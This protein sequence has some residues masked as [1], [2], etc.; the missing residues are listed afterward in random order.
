MAAKALDFSA[1]GYLRAAAVAP[2]VRIADPLANAQQILGHLER[3]E[4]SGAA[5]ALFPELS[6]TGYT[7]EDLFCNA[8]LLQEAWRAL[9]LI[10]ERASPVVA[11]VGLPWASPDSRLFNCAAVVSGGR[12]A[13]LVP[14]SCIPNHGEFYERRW[15][16]S[17]AGLNLPVESNL[18]DFRVCPNQLF[19]IGQHRIAVELCE[20]LWAPQPPGAAHSLAGAE[21]VLNLS[22]S[23]ELVAKA[24][25]RRDL[26]RMA[27]GAWLC[28][29]LYAGAGAAESTKDLVFGGHLLAAENG[30]LLAESERFA[31]GATE[32]LAEFDLDKLRH[33]RLR[34]QSFGASARLGEHHLRRLAAAPP[35]LAELRRR[36]DPHPFVPSDEAVFSARAQEI[37]AIQSVGLAR[38]MQAVGVERL[39]LGLSG[40]LDS[41]LALLVCLEALERLHLP[42]ANL[43][44]FSLPGPGTSEHTQTTVTALAAATAISLR[45]ISI[46]PA[47]ARHLEDLQHQMQNDVVFENAQ[48]RQRTQLLF[49]AANMVGG[50]LVGTGDLSE[51]ALGWCTFNADQMSGYNVN[52]SVPKTL[53]AYLVRWCAQHRAEAGLAA[54]LQRVLETPISPELQTTQGGGISQRTEA[55][56]GPYELH[57]FFLHHYVRNGF[58]AQKIF[59]LAKLAFAGRHQPQDVKSWLKVFFE[60]FFAQ[61]FKRTT[62]PPGPKVG[63]VSL[64]PRGDW[65]MPDE[66]EA[67]SLLAAIDGLPA[68]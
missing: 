27:S 10:A 63:S 38:R 33:D 53:V 12:V 46:S 41:T 64:S 56:I 29:Y 34:N 44:G 51:L 50:V 8:G 25:Y 14:K 45:E 68:D 16:A 49:N 43:H 58:S 9:E 1:F 35:R 40:G 31:S 24:D 21:L 30:V 36:I 20:D 3:L 15:F 13:G 47:V 6:L 26:V 42:A 32:L 2:R 23:N 52:A 57:D 54:A 17:G 11:V 48:A 39:V 66:A 65:R 55:I 60:R 28:G 5:L 22:A 7:A 59:A 19:Q 61:Q 62:L 4:G 18:G 37:L 67:A